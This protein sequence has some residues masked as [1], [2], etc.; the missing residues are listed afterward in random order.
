MECN[1][2]YGFVINSEYLV[3]NEMRCIIRII[4]NKKLK[5][6]GSTSVSFSKT[7]MKLLSY[8]LEKSLRD[9]GAGIITREEIIKNVLDNIYV[10]SSN[11]KFHYILHEIK[12]KLSIIGLPEDFVVSYRAK[13]VRITNKSVIGLY[14]K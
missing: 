8:I 13:G 5:F 7:A 6:S 3:L 10:Y 14:I 4:S 1:G 12:E 11:Q 2:N 9:D